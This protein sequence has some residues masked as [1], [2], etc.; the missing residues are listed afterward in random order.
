MQGG[1]TATEFPPGTTKSLVERPQAVNVIWSVA[2]DCPN[3]AESDAD[4]K[5]PGPV[6]NEK[7]FPPKLTVRS[8]APET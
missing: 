7:S 1:A 8:S 4:R 5:R 6:G 2:A 3:D